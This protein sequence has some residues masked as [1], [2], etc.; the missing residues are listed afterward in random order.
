MS[1]IVSRI[2]RDQ[3]HL[4]PSI[5]NGERSRGGDGSFA[6]AAFTTEEENLV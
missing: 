4:A 2:C 3:Q 5:G 6:D 1:Q